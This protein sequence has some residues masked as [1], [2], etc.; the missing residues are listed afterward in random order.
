MGRPSGKDATAHTARRSSFASPFARESRIVLRI[1]ELVASFQF[2]FGLRRTKDVSPVADVLRRAMHH[3]EALRVR[4]PLREALRLGRRL[5]RD[6]LGRD[7]SLGGVDR[8]RI[9]ALPFLEL[10]AVDVDHHLHDFAS[11]FFP[12]LSLVMAFSCSFLE[13]FLPSESSLPLLISCPR[14]QT[15]AWRQSVSESAGT[16]RTPPSFSGATT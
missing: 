3:D 9:A 4:L 11:S 8:P 12:S 14:D 2:P 15:A 5:D 13:S 10:E 16:S 6:L 7:A 1:E